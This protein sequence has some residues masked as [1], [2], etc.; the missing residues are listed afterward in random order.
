MVEL[1]KLSA[2]Q[3]EAIVYACQRHEQFLPDGNRA[4]F[5]IGDGAGVGKVRPLFIQTA[6]CG[7]SRS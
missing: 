6:F 1:E 7:G 3:L 5:F 4:G 2:L